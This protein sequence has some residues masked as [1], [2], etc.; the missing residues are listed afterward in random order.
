MVFRRPTLTTSIWGLICLAILLALGFWQLERREWKQD[1]IATLETR[2]AKPAVPLPDELSSEWLYRP[3]LVEGEVASDQWFRF[4]GRSVDGEVGDVLMLLVRLPDGRLAVVQHGA[5]GF[6]AELPP[7]PS[8]V[9]KEGIVRDPPEAGLFTPDND[10]EDNEWYSVAPEAMAAAAGLPD[11]PVLDYYLAS[12]DW[13]PH[14]P[15]NHLEYAITWFSFAGIFVIIF[16]LF[17]RR[18]AK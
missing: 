18:R 5:I 14:L 10:P 2:L 15:N 7:L 9:A 4:P 8:G 3:V 6:G 16:A 11:A 13:R 1:L 17:H 12:A